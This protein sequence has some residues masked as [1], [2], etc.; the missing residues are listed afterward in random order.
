MKKGLIAF[1]ALLLCMGLVSCT[2]SETVSEEPIDIYIDYFRVPSLFTGTLVDGKPEGEGYIQIDID[3]NS[4]TFKGIFKDGNP[5]QGTV[6][7]MPYEFK[8]RGIRR[9]GTYN[10]SVTGLLPHGK[11]TFTELYDA[12]PFI[13][14]GSFADGAMIGEGAVEN[15][16]ATL[17]IF[18][19]EF[20][21]EYTGPCIDGEPEGIGEFT[22]SSVKRH[23]FYRGL[24][25][26]SRPVGVGYTETNLITVHF[27]DVDRPGSYQGDLL[28]GLPSGEGIFTAQ[29]D[30]KIPYTYTG[31]WLSGLYHGQGETIY[32]FPGG[33][34]VLSGTYEYGTFCFTPYDLFQSVRFLDKNQ[35]IF[36]ISDKTKAFIETNH[37]L[38]TEPVKD[39]SSHIDADFSYTEARDTPAS[40]GD[41]L[42]KAENLVVD[43][44]EEAT[45]GNEP[46]II[47]TAINPEAKEERYITYWQKDIGAVREGDFITLYALPMDF[48]KY[49]PA[50]GAAHIWAFCAG[51]AIDL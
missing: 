40:Y 33:D 8:L 43:D 9:S 48:T 46:I 25:R 1:F 3:K 21:G 29:T 50:K 14:T 38:F 13:Y 32:N 47:V 49:S 19:D 12:E 41:K 51:V 27:E 44:I 37:S 11:G 23:L 10:G 26:D 36:R 5:Y 18:D 35:P 20:Y 4:W 39:L 28:D 6:N 34:W 2:S 7:N 22:Y 30:D 31:P 16:P 15:W 45:V 17:S 42:I 24:I